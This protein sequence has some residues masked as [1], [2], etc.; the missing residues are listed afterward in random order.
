MEGRSVT[1]RGGEHSGGG[2]CHSCGRGGTGFSRSDPGARN[3]SAP[4]PWRGIKNAC[5][6]Q[7][8]Q[9]TKHFCSS[10]SERKMTWSPE[11][12]ASCP[13]W[14]GTWTCCCAAWSR[15]QRSGAGSDQ[16]PP[17]PRSGNS[18]RRATCPDCTDGSS[19]S[20]CSGSPV[21]QQVDMK[22]IRIKP[23]Y[24]T[25]KWAFYRHFAH[26]PALKYSLYSLIIYHKPN[27]HLINV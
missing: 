21:E 2:R 23:W 7:Q 25:T 8:L 17:G 15:S 24:P 19:G 4:L 27:K 14:L 6:L 16:P 1:H 3:L 26:M 10:Q 20:R 5:S 18:P 22:E 9:K 13:G 12:W 11:R